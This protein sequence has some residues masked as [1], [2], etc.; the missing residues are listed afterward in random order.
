[1]VDD[2]AYHPALRM[3]ERG[4]L[5][6]V[7]SDDPAYFGGYIN[8]NF[9]ALQ[10]ALQ[11]DSNAIVTLARNGFT[12]SFLP[13]AEKQTALAHLDA[14]VSKIAHSAGGPLNEKA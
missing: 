12:G 8:D 13:K 7:N 4:L 1:V 6:T 14:T 5:V 10:K 9:G 11:L 3:L 2:L